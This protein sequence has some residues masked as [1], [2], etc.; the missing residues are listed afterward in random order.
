M[1]IL[2]IFPSMTLEERYGRKVKDVSGVLPPLGLAYLAAVLEKRGHK[3]KIIDGPAMSLTLEELAWETEKA[4]PDIVGI[5]AITPI[6]HRAYQAATEIK[7][8][9]PKTP[10]VLGGPH[11]SLFPKET[12]LE[13]PSV[14]M[15]CVGEGEYTMLELVEALENGS[16]LDR[17]QGIAFRDGKKII[18]NPVRGFIENLDVLPFPAR[19]LLPMDKYRPL[20]NQ[21]RRLP[22]VH[23]MASRGCPFTCTYCSKAIF[24]RNTRIRSPNNV[25]AE[26]KHVRDK[27]KA[28]E[29]HFKDDTF[30]LQNTWVKKLC[31]LFNEEVPDLLW[32][33]FTRVDMVNKELLKTMHEAGCHR[34]GYGIESSNQELLDTIKKGITLDQIRNAVRWTKEAGIELGLSF[35]LALPGE[36]PEKAHD[37]I[38]FAKEL[39]PDYAQFCITTPY[40]GTELY[41]QAK[42][43]G[44]LIHDFPSYTIWNPV[45]IPHGYK[46][47]D[48]I[49]EMQ[50]KAFKS[51]YY[52]PSYILKRILKISSIQDIKRNVEGLKMVL[53]FSSHN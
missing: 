52:R 36:T 3:V 26:I 22:V 48:E 50:R 21:Y 38:K 43:Y 32:A 4:N 6:V 11:P 19:H 49:L 42:K 20:P 18:Q 41:N 27:Y 1:N 46:D 7:R 8:T 14:D 44:T 23:L 2:L 53:G 47:E 9:L 12:L 39:D 28:R 37:T 45:F 33:C 31:H 24:G 15:V 13:N 51:F 34:I 35:M 29:I 30:T 40:P 16:D 5:S 17:I 10:I 25:I